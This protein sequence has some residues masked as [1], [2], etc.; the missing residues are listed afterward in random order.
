MSDTTPSELDAVLAVAASSAPAFAMQSIAERAALLHELADRIDSAAAQ[1]VPIA[2]AES[3]LPADRLAN[4]VERTSGQLRFLAEVILDGQ[5]LDAT[6]DT[7]DPGSPA[8]RPDVRSVN[9]PIGPALVFAASNFPFAFSTAGGDTAAALAAGC[10]VVLKS[11]PGHPELSTRVG[12]LVQEVFGPAFAI[13]DGIDAGRLAIVDPRIKV[14]AFTGS[15]VGGRSLFDL[16]VGRV[17]PIPFYGELGSVNPAVVSPGAAAARAPQIAADF[18]ASFTLGVG[19][20]CTKPGLLFMPAGS[21][22]LEEIVT[23]GSVVAGGPMLGDWV[24]AGHAARLAQLRD[25]PGVR[26]VLDGGGTDAIGVR[27]S[28]LAI[29]VADLLRG[30]HHLVEECFGPT[31]IAIEYDDIADVPAVLDAVG[32]SLT[33]SLHVEPHEAVMLRPIADAL[34]RLAGRIVWNGWTTGVRVS[35][36]MQHG[37]PWPASTSASHTSVGA[38]SIRRFIRPIAFQN[39]P[40]AYLPLALR[41]R[42]E[43]G[44][45]RRIDGVVT[46]ADMNERTV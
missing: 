14:A 24:Q 7:E 44:I 35:W 32:G 4:E 5:W 11:H 12:R 25:S 37:G 26:L 40:E 27:P 34:E 23:A 8:L 10:P 18:V 19:Q 38:A 41:N 17:D 31:A 33:A 28:I 29:T 42:N 43:L 30:P 20:F 16:A 45:P 3:H 9:V 1:L 13:I 22:L 39:A 46:D 21:A 15:T 2:Q 6:I 36:A